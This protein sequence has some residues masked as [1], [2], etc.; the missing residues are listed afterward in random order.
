VIQLDGLFPD[1]YTDPSFADLQTWILIAMGGF[2]TFVTVFGCLLVF[3]QLGLIPVNGAGQIVL[4]PEAIRRS[5]KLMT[6]DEVKRLQ[7]GG[8]LYGKMADSEDNT[9]QSLT[10]PAN[11]MEEGRGVHST[12]A[13]RTANQHGGANDDVVN[14]D[15]IDHEHA[16]DE[17]ENTCAVCL[18]ELHVA[19][20]VGGLEESTTLCLPCRHKFHVDCIIPWLTERQGTCPLCKF[21]V[22]Q[23]VLSHDDREKPVNHSKESF[24]KRNVSRLMRFGWSP[25]NA[26]G[27]DSDSGASIVN[28]IVNSEQGSSNDGSGNN[29][30]HSAVGIEAN[31]LDDPTPANEIQMTTITT[32]I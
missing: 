26:E 2:F 13:N 16:G 11:S 7:F 18:D 15:T 12:N 8:D 4:T 6:M 14:A 24:F 21:E 23:F 32:S 5:R 30:N 31:T 9:Q 28:S 10:S 20:P 17:E 19:S 27:S 25:V 22:L 1:F 29:R 3:V